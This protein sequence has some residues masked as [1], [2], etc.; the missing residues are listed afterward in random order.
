M[1][2]KTF[3][4]S[5]ILIYSHDLDAGANH[6]MAADILDSLWDLNLG[7][8]SMQVLQEFYVN[9]TRKIRRPLP[10]ESARAIVDDFS[11]WRRDDTSRTND[12]LPHRG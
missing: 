12:R 6:G 10:R 3:V 5:N 11:I 1:S 8:L 7:V 9:I 4:D 2:G